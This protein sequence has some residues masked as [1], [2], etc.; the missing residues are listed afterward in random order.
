MIKNTKQQFSHLKLNK[1]KNKET[2]IQMIFKDESIQNFVC[3][4]SIF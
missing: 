2:G 3:N 4:I 1:N